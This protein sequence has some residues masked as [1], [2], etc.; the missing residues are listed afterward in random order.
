MAALEL[1]VWAVK[2]CYIESSSQVH[3]Q[4]FD[5][6][7]INPFSNFVCTAVGRCLFFFIAFVPPGPQLCPPRDSSTIV[8]PIGNLEIGTCRL[9]TVLIG[10]G[11]S[12]DTFWEY[13]NRGLR[14]TKVAGYVKLTHLYCMSPLAPTQ[15][16]CG[17][18]W[19]KCE[20]RV[21][22]WRPNTPKRLQVQWRLSDQ[23]YPCCIDGVVRCLS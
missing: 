19:P 2:F 1:G 7:W 15:R 6:A 3:T 9:T 23:S 17:V 8:S 20:V 10:R 22:D 5:S 21:S 14:L 16:P 13:G 12:W 11:W 18:T 4:Q